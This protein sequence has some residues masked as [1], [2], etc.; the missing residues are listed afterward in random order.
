MN[1]I[2]IQKPIKAAYLNL[3]ALRLSSSTILKSLFLTL[4]QLQLFASRAV[5]LLVAPLRMVHAV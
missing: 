1:V 2:Q 3:P 5:G 4:G